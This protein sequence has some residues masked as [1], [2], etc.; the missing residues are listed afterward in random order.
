MGAVDT[1][2]PVVEAGFRLRCGNMKGGSP[3][4]CRKEGSPNALR[5]RS[6]RT[7][8]PLLLLVMATCS[9]RGTMGG[10]ARR[11]FEVAATAG[12]TTGRGRKTT[13]DV[14]IGTRA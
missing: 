14:E 6:R 8:S 5:Y 7:S 13:C 3:R 11:A 1:S 2:R 9:S 4:P 12:A 10:A